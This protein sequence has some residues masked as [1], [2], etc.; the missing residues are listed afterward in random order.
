MK[1][2]K[3]LPLAAIMASLL[4]VVFFA[5]CAT[6]ARPVV[7]EPGR[8][9]EL[10][11]LHT[12]D[13]HG[14]VLSANGVGG[15]AERATFV[16]SVRAANPNVLLVDAGDINTGTALSNMFAAELDI[17]AYNLM[18]YDAMT[19]GNHEFNRGQ[20][21]LD[22]Q[23]ALADFP[24]VSSNISTGRGRF[25]GGHQYLVKN[26][27]GFRIGII[28]LT[29][30]RTLVISH[31]DTGRY[32]TFIPELEAA[33]NAVDLLRNRERVDIVIALTH[34]GDVREYDDHVTTR[35][36]AL[37]VP[38]IDIIVDGHTHT[39]FDEPARVGNTWLVS[40]QDWGRYVGQG[41]LTIVDGELVRFNWELVPITTQAFPP[42]PQVSAMLA[43]YIARAEASLRE[44]V[45]EAS[46][47]FIFTPRL[48]RF[49]ETAI[50]NMICDANVWYVRNVLNQEIDFAFHNGGNIRTE[51]P[52]G[53]LT[54][55]H[56][57]NVLPFENILH[58]V[59]LR[60][61]E[62]IELFNF[63]ATIPQGNGGFP[64]FSSEV[65][66]TL[67]VPNRTVR[68]L[69]IGGAPVD[70]NRIYRFVTNDFILEGGDGYA[71]LTRAHNRL[72]TSLLLSYVVIEYIA[73]LQGVITPSTDGRM[74]VI[75]GAAPF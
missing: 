57:L 9:Y 14:R 53:Q 3:K 18:G 45:G 17:R 49:G 31:T 40:A 27:E 13:H 32:F 7:R 52:R 26:Y 66:F 1:F 50:G 4:V 60:G 43:P 42:D 30:L 67:D 12:N 70:P 22:R 41:R 75:G 51:L 23:I 33:R 54:R 37:S 35:D 62:I 73:S 25:L 39:R 55:E 16:R 8:V 61:S 46:D 6:G 44:V 58:V 20:A 15:L 21:Q 65:R 69:T 2:G 38:G 56:I 63:I 34:M 59:S 10:I 74:V 47:T 29:T 64:Q 24:F 72:D 11:L 48:T 68:N 28:G 19:F 71:V 5:A 36:L